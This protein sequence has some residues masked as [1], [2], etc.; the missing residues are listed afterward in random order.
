MLINDPQGTGTV[1]VTG[2]DLD[3]LAEVLLT[4]RQTLLYGSPSDYV[5]SADEVS[6]LGGDPGLRDGWGEWTGDQPR[7]TEALARVTLLVEEARL[8]RDLPG[9]LEALAAGQE[10]STRQREVYD[11][12]LR[13][14]VYAS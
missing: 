11:L 6:A 5:L 1:D 8:Q 9:A 10:L 14:Q 13:E 12:Y 3:E 4:L 7:V 2:W